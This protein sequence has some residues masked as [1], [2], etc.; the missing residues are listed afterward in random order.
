MVPVRP[1]RQIVYPLEELGIN[2]PSEQVSKDQVGNRSSSRQ[3]GIVPANAGFGRW[4]G[5]TILVLIGCF[6]ITLNMVSIPLQSQLCFCMTVASSKLE[7]QAHYEQQS[8][9][10]SAYLL[11]AYI[12]IVFFH[13][14]TFNLP[15][16]F[17]C[18]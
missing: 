7:F 6:L 17:K 16:H 3:R 18:T 14:V 13:G 11:N 2:A 4:D 1:R 15:T 12:L 8:L 9:N 5:I 10:Y